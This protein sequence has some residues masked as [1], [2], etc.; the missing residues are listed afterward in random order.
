MRKR[1]KF[2]FDGGFTLVELVVSMLCVSIVMI[3]VMTWLLVGIRVEKSAADTM[4]RQQTARVVISLLE[5]MTSSGKVSQVQETGAV[6]VNVGDD[7]ISLEEHSGG[8][9]TMQYRLARL[10][11]PFR[12]PLPYI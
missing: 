11:L 9:G 12:K 10:V 2:R 7:D 1:M 5:S 8:S 6:T 4:E 3:G